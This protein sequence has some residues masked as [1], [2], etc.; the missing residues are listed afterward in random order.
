[1]DLVSEA[2][3]LLSQGS[4]SLLTCQAQ[5][6]RSLDNSSHWHARSTGLHT[7][8]PPHHGYHHWIRNHVR[9]IHASHLRV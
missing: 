9:S 6:E 2:L 4:V 1:M 7:Y 5:R 8:L 3:L